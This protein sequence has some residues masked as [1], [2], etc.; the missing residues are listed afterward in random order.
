MKFPMR[1][2]PGLRQLIRYG[3]VGLLNNMLGYLVYLGLTWTGLDPKIVISIL[4]PIGIAVGYFSHLRYS[5]SY[6]DRGL[7]VLLRY[8]IAYLFGYIVNFAMLYLLSEKLKFP[9]QAVQALAIFVVAGILFLLL[10]FF[11][12]PVPHNNK[13]ANS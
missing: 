5:F 13:A 1:I 2:S 10:K 3:V 12:F 6:G 7:N 11:V 8:L 4:Y 9:H